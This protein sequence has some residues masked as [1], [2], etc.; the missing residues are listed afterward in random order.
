MPNMCDFAKFLKWYDFEA[1]FYSNIRLAAL[2]LSG[3]LMKIAIMASPCQGITT[4]PRIGPRTDI[5]LARNIIIVKI[6]ISADSTIYES[7]IYPSLG[8]ILAKSR[9]CPQ[10]DG[11]RDIAGR[12]DPL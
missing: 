3:L 1:I 11:R 9:V 4:R 5:V 10:Y 7:R 6:L 8:W 12:G 2:P